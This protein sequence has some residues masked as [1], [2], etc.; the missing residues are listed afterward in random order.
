MITIQ[1]QL[2]AEVYVT[3]ICVESFSVNYLVR[4]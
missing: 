2:A 3:F 1:T 4:Y